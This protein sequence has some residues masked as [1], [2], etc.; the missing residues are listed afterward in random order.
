M[1]FDFMAIGLFGFHKED[2]WRRRKVAEVFGRI[3]RVAEGG[4]FV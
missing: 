1:I 2:T 4:A 3:G